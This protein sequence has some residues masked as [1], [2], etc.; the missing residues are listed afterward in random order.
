MRYRRDVDGLRAVAVLPV[1][2][3]HAGLRSFPGGFVGVDVFFVISGFVITG[4]LLDAINA[5]RFSIISFYVRRCRRILPA[6]LSTVLVTTIGVILLLSPEAWQD[7]SSSVLATATFASNVYFWRKSGYFDPQSDG[8]PL[9]H[10][11][12]LA[13]EEQ[14]YIVIP[15]ALWLGVW[16]L[17]RR[18]WWLFALGASLSLAFSTYLIERAPSA[19]FYLLPGRAW[20]LLVGCLLVLAPLPPLRIRAIREIVAV[21]GAGLIAWAV[22]AFNADTPFPGVAATVPAFGA[23]LLIYAGGTGSSSV[24]RALSWT[25]IVGIGLISYSA[26]LIHWPLI[27]L[28]RAVQLRDLTASQ[29]VVVVAVSLALAVLSWRYVEAPYRHPIGSDRPGRVL[30]AAAVALCG[31]LAVGTGIGKVAASQVG[32]SLPD[33]DPW[34]VGRCFLENEPYAEWAGKPCIRTQGSTAN[35]VLWGDSFAAHYIPG[36]QAAA[37]LSRDIVQYTSAGCPPIFSY[38]SI[39]IP[40]CHDF[41][42][43]IFD[44]IARFH[45]DTVIMSARWD[46]LGARGLSGLKDTVDRLKA[47]GLRVYVFGESPTFAFNVTELDRRG[48]GRRPDGTAWWFSTIQPSYDDRVREAAGSATFIDPMAALCSGGMCMYR[49]SNGLMYSDYGHFSVVG[50]RF[51]VESYFPLRSPRRLDPV[52]SL[53]ERSSAVR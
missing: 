20:E 11:W 45:A 17:R 18:V 49:D 38:E 14:F 37:P 16:L 30:G 40:A 4:G 42:S 22:L 53:V 52:A 41:N 7:F 5:D 46:L 12:S 6:L 31:L 19:D 2:L 21:T 32:P 47:A 34:L 28:A 3:F 50:S 35:A 36:L 1:M 8:R 48:V 43:H 27:V 15:V 9:L 23:A 25:P 51:A 26:Y 44:V 13:V 10:T 39:A 24:S 33:S 29:G